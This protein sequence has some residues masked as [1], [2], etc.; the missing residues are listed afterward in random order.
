LQ[1]QGRMIEEEPNIASVTANVV[2]AETKKFAGYPL[3]E[4][5]EPVE[6]AKE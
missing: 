2:M 6:Q 3:K 1:E 5:I 4:L